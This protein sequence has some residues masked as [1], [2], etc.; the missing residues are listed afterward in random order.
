MYFEEI[1]V[2]SVRTPMWSSGEADLVTILLPA[3]VGFG[4]SQVILGLLLL[5]RNPRKS[6]QQRFYGVVLISL[7]AYFIAPFT[8]ETPWHIGVI[9]VMTAL[10]GMFWLFSASLFDDHFELKFWQLALVF[11]TVFLPFIELLTRQ[12]GYDIAPTLFFVL[13]D[14]PMFL[15]FLLVGLALV[16]VARHW[17]VDLIQSRRDLRLWFCSVNGV[18]LFTLLVLRE[19]F[20]PYF[21]WLDYGQYAS[22][23]CIILVTNVMFLRISSGVLVDN[24]AISQIHLPH[25]LENTDSNKETISQD[26]EYK[27]SMDPIEEQVEKQVSQHWVIDNA[28]VDIPTE[29]LEQI[30]CAMEEE[31]IYRDMDITIGL[32]AYRLD[33]PEYKLRAVINRGL[34]Y[35]NFNDFLNSYRIKE[36]AKRLVSTED[37]KHSV[38]T[39]ALDTGFR[40][41]SSFNKTFK[42]TYNIT[43]T[44]YRRKFSYT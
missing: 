33:I 40:S 8:V 11:I 37:E 2:Q 6:I 41:L 13:H 31:C 17:Q 15:E 12:L 38:L 26:I 23:G 5:Y 14:L 20:Y 22:A 1:T 43:P 3:F 18:Y 32:L 10:P 39:I 35:R 27:L 25:K 21:T 24:S 19:V 4:I 42:E 7:L 30:R 34:G 36:V 16:A 44:A 28:E 29:T 9:T